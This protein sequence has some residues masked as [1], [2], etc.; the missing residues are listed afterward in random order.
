MSDFGA[1]VGAGV[2]RSPGPAAPLPTVVIG[3]YLGAGKTTLVNHLLREEGLRGG[4]RIAVLVKDFGEISVDADLIVGADGEVL[5]LAG[6][7]VCCSFGA[8]LV[9]TLQRVAVR[10]P[11]PDV[12]LIETSGVGLPLAVARAAALVPGIAVDGIVVVV[13]APLVRGQVRARYVGETVRQQLHE[14]DLIVLSKADLVAAAGEEVGEGGDEGEGQGPCGTLRALGALG[15]LRAW[16]RTQGVAAPCVP[17]VRGQVDPEVVL[18]LRGSSGALTPKRGWRKPDAADQRYVARSRHFSAAVDVAALAAALAQ[19]GVLRAKGVLLDLS[20][21]WQE[22][23]LA[24]RR[25]DVR[26]ARHA[27]VPLPP[28]LPPGSAA[29]QAAAG[30]LVTITLRED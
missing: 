28:S 1:D 6:G 13:D 24:G 19:E 18:G 17:A 9:G 14:A 15:A 27:L 30:R 16:L 21:Q 4:R 8:D 20:G 23:Q 5:S 26:P 12:V 29:L 7:C 10:E 25:V 22:L 11:R 3:G 2:G